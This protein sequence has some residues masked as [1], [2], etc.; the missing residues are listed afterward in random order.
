MRFSRN[1]QPDLAL[2]AM[3]MA[4]YAVHLITSPALVGAL[5]IMYDE[6]VHSLLIAAAGP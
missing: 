6:A 3:C 1:V 5:E 2:E 4:H